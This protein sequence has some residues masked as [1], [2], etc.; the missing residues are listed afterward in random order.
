[1]SRSRDFEA[2][3]D[4]D[5]CYTTQTHTRVLLSAALWYFCSVGGYR[6]L[7][8]SREENLKRENE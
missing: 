2:E 7:I 1:M 5:A 4:E 3:E 6:G 8:R